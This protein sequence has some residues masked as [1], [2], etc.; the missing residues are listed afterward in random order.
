MEDTPDKEAYFG[1]FEQDSFDLEECFNASTQPENSSLLAARIAER[2]GTIIRST[3]KTD[4]VVGEPSL[5]KPTASTSCAGQAESEA[6]TVES[7]ASS[8][9]ASTPLK[10]QP[11]SLGVL[12]P[13]I[14]SEELRKKATETSTLDIAIRDKIKSTLSTLQRTLDSETPP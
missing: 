1:S 6:R 2:A 11:Y 13:K 14:G 10:F 4:K 8:I 3:P 9:S 7:V 5:P 12:M